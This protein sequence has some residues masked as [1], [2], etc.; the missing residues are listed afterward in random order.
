MKSLLWRSHV[1]FRDYLE[2]HSDAAKQYAALKRALAAK[3]PNDR[4]A[5]TTGKEEFLRS[6]LKLAATEG[7]G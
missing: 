5:Y 4:P 6:I 7:P 2:R 1:A 3:F